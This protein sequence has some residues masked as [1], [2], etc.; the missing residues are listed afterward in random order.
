MNLQFNDAVIECGELNARNPITFDSCMK[1]IE[2]Y[3]SELH[4][5]A[6]TLRR[7]IDPRL[8]ENPLY[9]FGPDCSLLM[10]SL[11]MLEVLPNRI[12]LML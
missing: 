3:R 7:F 6:L 5:G 4:T 9:I 12:D 1:I 11:A 2:P 10:L 8:P